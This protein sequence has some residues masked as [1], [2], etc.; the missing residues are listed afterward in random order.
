MSVEKL[1]PSISLPDRDG[2][3]HLL[4]DYK[5]KWVL[6]YFYPKDDTPGCTKEA[7]GIRDA[8]PSFK[9]LDAVV[10][11]ISVDSP[12][13]HAKFVEKYALPFALLADEKKVAVNAY[14]VWQKKKFMGREYMG[15]VRT[16]FL[17]D[18][19][20]RIAKVY[21]NVKPETHA[22]EVLEDLKALKKSAN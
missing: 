6:L 5:G 14:G 8:F 10:L 15:T 19:K 2:N 12:Q 22:E 21:D 20:G 11:G 1:A 9:K 3:I 17:I 18:P 16:S 4:S 7:C 13:K